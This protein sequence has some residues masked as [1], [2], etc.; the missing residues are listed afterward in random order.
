MPV[1]A[2]GHLWPELHVQLF[3][4]CVSQLAYKVTE[5]LLG[6]EVFIYLFIFKLLEAKI[7]C[8]CPT[9]IQINS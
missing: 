2:A 7:A 1:Q 8:F 6:L 5:Q 4:T 9:W 3:F